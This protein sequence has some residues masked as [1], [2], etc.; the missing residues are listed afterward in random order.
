MIINKNLVQFSQEAN[1]SFLPF[2]ASISKSQS[3]ARL[4]Q[5]F[6]ASCI[7]VSWASLSGL[8]QMQLLKRFF[9]QETHVT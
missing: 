7:I 5:S 3:L 9:T 2:V 4:V 6:N 8:A 1:E